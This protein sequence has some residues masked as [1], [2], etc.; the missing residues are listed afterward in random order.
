MGSRFGGFVCPPV[1]VG[2]CGV[3]GAEST[4]GIISQ[5]SKKVKLIITV[6]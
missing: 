3:L 4:I 6:K 2:L 1:K 5:L